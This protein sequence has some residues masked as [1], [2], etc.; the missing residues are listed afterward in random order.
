M[1]WCLNFPQVNL[2]TP[3]QKRKIACGG[4]GPQTVKEVRFGVENRIGSFYTRYCQSGKGGV[5]YHAKN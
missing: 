3:L 4:K 5:R 2:H 1:L